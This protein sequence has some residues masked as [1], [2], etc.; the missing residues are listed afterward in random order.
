MTNIEFESVTNPE[1]EPVAVALCAIA[2]TNLTGNNEFKG[3]TQTATPV[4]FTL[5]NDYSKWQIT[6]AGQTYS[7][8]CR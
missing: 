7:G 8:V 6:H 4:T 1:L 3:Q 2:Q 5:K